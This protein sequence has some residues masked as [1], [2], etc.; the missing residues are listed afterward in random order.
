MEDSSPS[1]GLPRQAADNT[2]QA[3]VAKENEQSDRGSRTTGSIAKK[4]GSNLFTLS[5]NSLK[6]SLECALGKPRCF[7]SL[8]IILISRTEPLRSKIKC[9]PKRFMNAS[10]DIIPSHENLAVKCLS[11]GT[12]LWAGE[13]YDD[14]PSQR[15]YYTLSGAWPRKLVL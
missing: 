15:P 11:F 9:I 8:L 13:W 12:E 6:D 7:P 4:S 2:S 3:V 1:R 14:L 5:L 10:Q